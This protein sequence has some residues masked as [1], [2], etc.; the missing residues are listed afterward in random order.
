[1]RRT[2]RTAVEQGW[3]HAEEIGP[4]WSCS[5]RDSYNHFL[6]RCEASYS[7]N[8]DDERRISRESDD[9]QRTDQ[10]LVWS[11]ALNT[12]FPIEQDFFQIFRLPRAMTTYA[13][14]HLGL[15][16]YR[17][18]SYFILEL[19]SVSQ[20]PGSSSI[21]LQSYHVT[22]RLSFSRK[23]LTVPKW[24]RSEQLLTAEMPRAVE[25]RTVAP[26]SSRYGSRDWRVISY[27][28]FGSE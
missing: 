23:R 21:V 8:C 1:M 4:A 3:S 7:W 28:L 12:L 9:P 20:R 2:L 22:L 14:S 11:G 13:A 17:L 25:H 19:Q 15:P 16:T 10:P 5:V 24:K 18:A 26:S 6:W 27:H